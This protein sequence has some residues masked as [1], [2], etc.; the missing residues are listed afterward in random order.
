MKYLLLLALLLA[1]TSLC[2]AD[3]KTY[4][5]GKYTYTRCEGVLIQKC[6]V[7]GGIKYCH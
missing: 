3:C 6:H 2:F 5:R 4:T 1:I 7:T